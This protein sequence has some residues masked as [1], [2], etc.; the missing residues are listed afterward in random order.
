MGFLSGRLLSLIGL[1]R[2]LRAGKLQG[3]R[4]NQRCGLH[5]V[6]RQDAKAAA[7]IEGRKVA[8]RSNV[9]QQ[10]AGDQVSGQNEEEIDDAPAEKNIRHK[11]ESGLSTIPM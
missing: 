8:G 4:A 10:D 9:G 11:V 2:R 6:D 3:N 1:L 7:A 5:A